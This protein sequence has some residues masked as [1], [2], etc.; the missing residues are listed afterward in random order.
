MSTLLLVR[1][2]QASFFEDDYDRLSELGELQARHLG[3]YLA[4]LGV[5]YNEVYTGPALRH[6]R[7]AEL[8]GEEL[9]KAELDWAKPAVLPELNE[10]QADQ[11]LRRSADDLSRRDDHFRELVAAYRASHERTD[12]NRNFQLLFEAVVKLWAANELSLPG[13]EGWD[14]FTQRV[15]RAI[16]RIVTGE[17]RGRRVLAFSSVG[18]ISIFLKYALATTNRHALELGWRLRNC[19][20]TEFVF[21]QDR[22]TLDSFNSL[23]HLDEADLITFR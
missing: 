1:H 19:S 6:Q 15:E 9:A 22:L 13:V 10:H 2:A 4:R 14:E 12:I 8:V 18:P 11:I 20:L 3:Q 7:T 21:T 5:S 17:G 16:R 23:P